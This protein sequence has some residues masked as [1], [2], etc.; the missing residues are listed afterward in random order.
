MTTSPLSDLKVALPGSALSM[1]LLRSETDELD[2]RWAEQAPVSVVAAPS[3][4]LKVVNE[5]LLERVFGPQ[6]ARARR[7]IDGVGAETAYREVLD[8]RDDGALDDVLIEPFAAVEQ[9]LVTA[10]VDDDDDAYRTALAGMMLLAIQIR[11]RS[12]ARV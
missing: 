2:E 4:I 7:A 5:A 9:A 12:L 10:Q 3:Q 11:L 1:K 8:A 6:A